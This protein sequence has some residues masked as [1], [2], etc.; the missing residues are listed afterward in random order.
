[1]ANKVYTYYKELP[2][3]A[4]GVVVVGGIAIVYF[5]S[6]QIIN[7]I[8]NQAERKFDLQESDSA[9]SDLQNLAQQGIKPTVSNSQIDN[10]INSLVESMNDCGTD[11]NAIYN[12]FK[13]LNNTADVYALLK[14]WQIRYY[15]PCAISN[16]ISFAKYQFNNKAFGGNL[17]TWL[18]YDM[19]ATEIGKI[20]KILSDKGIN[21]KF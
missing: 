8:R 21:Y 16:P 19:T 12:Q 6:K 17:S 7:R 9:S 14:R 20:N 5:T 3:W 2:S 10:I 4:K 13:K 1:M 18:T 11:E 15:R